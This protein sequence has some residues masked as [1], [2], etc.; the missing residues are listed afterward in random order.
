MGSVT[1]SPALVEIGLGQGDEEAVDPVDALGADFAVPRHLRPEEQ[2]HVFVFQAQGVGEGG[3]D[4][5]FQQPLDQLVAAQR[6]CRPGAGP[7]RGSSRRS[8][9]RSCTWRSSGR[10]CRRRCRCRRCGFRWPRRRRSRAGRAPPPGRRASP[11]R[12][13][14]GAAAA[15]RRRQSSRGRLG[16]LLRAWA[17]SGRGPGAAWRTTAAGPGPASA[18]RSRCRSGGRRWPRRCPGSARA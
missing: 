12:R 7:G 14:P 9:T 11:G 13:R 18:A 8:S 5:H 16:R 1:S 6:R 10:W 3:D 2:L 17:S 4:D 15:G